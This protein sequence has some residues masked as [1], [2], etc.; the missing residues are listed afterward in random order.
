MSKETKPTTVVVILSKD[1][2]KEGKKT[3]KPSCFAKKVIAGQKVHTIRANF[4]YWAKKISRVKDTAGKLSVREWS[5]A[6]YRSPQNIILIVPA[7]ITGVQKL[8]LTRSREVVS[9]FI[10]GRAEP[11]LKKRT[12]EYTALVDG[13]PIILE[14][15]AANDGLTVEEFKEWF[16]PVFD[17]QEAQTPQ[18]AG[19]VTIDF[20]IIHFTSFRY[21]D[22][23]E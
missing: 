2:F 7:S 5:A 19:S 15:L 6:P 20:A 18:E 12:E 3:N 11:F 21:K 13:E 17:K 4:D 23:Q 14:T 8:Q 9:H 16:A 1:T 22:F 10:E